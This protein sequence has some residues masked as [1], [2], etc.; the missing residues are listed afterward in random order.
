LASSF[1]CLTEFQYLPELKEKFK[2]YDNLVFLYLSKDRSVPAEKFRWK[3]MIEKKNLTGSHYF[4]TNE[5]FDAIWKEAVKDTTI[6]KAFPHYLIV[7]R[8]GIVVNN[9]APRPS[10][11][12]L[13]KE[14][15]NI[16]AR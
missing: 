13:I 2:K 1:A 16:L 7:N 9:N 3:K 14:L 11:E 10:E 12:S 4:M 6:M 5:K 15:T 8:D